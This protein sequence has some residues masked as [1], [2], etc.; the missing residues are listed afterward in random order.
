MPN[1][2]DFKPI[3]SIM[4]AAMK[5]AGGA[6]KKLKKLRAARKAA[7]RRQLAEGFYKK[8]GWPQARIDSHLDGID[9]SKPVSVVTIPKGT[10]VVQY[11][12]PG[13]QAGNYFAPPGTPATQLGINPTGR[14]PKTFTA[15]QDVQALRSTASA[16]LDTWSGKPFQTQ[17]GGTQYFVPNPGGFQ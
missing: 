10:K 16:P 17:G 5:A 9:F 12:V 4:G 15:T 2:P 8:A 11:Q 14:V 3:V 1:I 7:K 13:K 6:L